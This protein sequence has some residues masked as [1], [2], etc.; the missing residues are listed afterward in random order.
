[1]STLIVV[2]RREHSPPHRL[3]G[4]AGLGREYRPRRRRG[5]PPG[6]RHRAEGRRP[7]RVLSVFG[8]RPEAIKMAPLVKLLEATPGV[9][10]RV[11]VTAQHRGMLD[12]VLSLFE[13]TP[14]A[15]LNVMRPGQDLYA[16]TGNILGAIG[17]VYAELAPDV[18]LVHGDT[19]TTM[20]AS[21]AAYYQRI[22]VGHVEAGLRT[23]NMYSPWPEEGNR[24][25]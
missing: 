13:I 22:P 17:P 14:D 19:T 16:L 2:A 21:L 10:S 15:D 11:C 12:Q 6:A 25:L 20:A 5:T 8:T 18:V 9:E 23:R 7:M 1:S 3:P 4:H 24:K